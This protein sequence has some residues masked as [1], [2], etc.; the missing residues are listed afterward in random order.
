[1]LQTH[2]RNDWN[3]T[4]PMTKLAPLKSITYLTCPIHIYY[5]FHQLLFYSHRRQ[6]FYTPLPKIETDTGRRRD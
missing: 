5:S 1:M 4:N 6:L 3:A 2:A